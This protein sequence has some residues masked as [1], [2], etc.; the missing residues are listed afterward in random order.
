LAGFVLGATP[1]TKRRSTKM[2]NE[3]S[4]IHLSPDSTIPVALVPRALY[5]SNGT[6][7]EL[8]RGGQAFQ[9]RTMAWEQVKTVRV[10]REGD[11][12]VEVRIIQSRRVLRNK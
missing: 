12:S 11:G 3:D 8:Y 2:K 4:V 9:P 1:V 7:F 6:I 10:T 5:E